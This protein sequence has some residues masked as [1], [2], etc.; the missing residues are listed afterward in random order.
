MLRQLEYLVALAREEH[1]GRAASAC[2]ASQ[3]ALSTGLRKLELE[4]GVTLVHHG[5]R[6]AGLTAEGRRVL[7]WANRILAER[8]GLH[9]DL[10][11]MREGLSVTLR[12][13]A[14]PTAMAI[15]GRLSR[16]FCARHPLA[17]VRVEE[18]P[19]T[20]IVQRLSD[21]TLDAGL[22]YLDPEPPQGTR[23]VELYRE[24]YLLLAPE[25]RFPEDRCVTWADV[26]EQPLCALV[27]LM[28]NRRIIEAAALTEGAT[29]VPVVEV[30]SVAALYTHAAQGWSTVV[31]HT[32]LKSF[33]V[34]DG[35]RA[36]PLPPAAAPPVGVL[37]TADEPLSMVATALLDAIVGFV[38]DQPQSGEQ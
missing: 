5:R 25:S 30:D 10:V 29:V 19:A 21:Y 26:A 38:P 9:D 32:W 34:P 35:M 7:G 31:A 20:E 2:H 23:S 14:I 28:R 6:Y 24:R 8:D 3:P 18:L 22:T 12:L 4:L 37:T 11:R 16:L 33:G 13:G 36:V 17:R 15:T 1:F 27:R